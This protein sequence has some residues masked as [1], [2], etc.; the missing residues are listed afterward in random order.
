V[1]LTYGRDQD[2]RLTLV[3]P[4]GQQILLS[5]QNGSNGANYTNTNFVD[6]A[7][8][9][10]T[11][12]P[13]FTGNFAPQFDQGGGTMTSALVNGGA[14]A[15]G[16]WHL[17]VQNLGTGLSGLLNSWSLTLTAADAV[18]GVTDFMIPVNF[19]QPNFTTISNVAVGL[20]LQHPDLGPL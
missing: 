7:P 3:A 5:N 13:P 6:G 9:I 4:N 19:T 2:L 18:Q 12:N 1:N 15:N 14:P 11:G 8:S 10:T 17:L 20:S 16:T